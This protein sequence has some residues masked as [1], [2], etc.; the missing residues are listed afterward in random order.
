VSKGGSTPIANGT[1]DRETFVRVFLSLFRSRRTGIL[2]IHFGKKSRKLYFLGGEPIAFRSD[3]PEDD[4]GRTLVNAGLIAEKQVNWIRQKL[5]EGEVLEQAIVMSG[6][7]TTSQI[8]EHKRGRL[9]AN[10]GSPLLWGS[11]TWAF[12]PR[13][14]VRVN[15]IDPTLRPETGSLAALWAA[16][17]QH[18]SMDEVFPAVTD[19]KAGL[20]GL[21]P[22]CGALF[23][24]LEVSD[25]FSGVVDAIGPGSTVEDIFR[26]VPDNTGNLVKLLWFLEAAGLVHRE[27]R[28]RDPS[29]N[30]MIQSAFDNWKPAAAPKTTQKAAAPKTTQKAAAPK[31]ADSGGSPKKAM[32]DEAKADA[33]GAKKRRPP[34]TDDQIRSTHRKRIGRDFYSFLGLPP[35]SPKPAIDRKCKGLARRW[36]LPGKQ[37]ALSPE[38]NQKVGELLAGVQLV[39]R[40][41]TN[42][43]HRAEYDKRMEQGR[44]PKVGEIHGGSPPGETGGS[45]GIAADEISM[46]PAHQRAR[47]HMEQDQYTDA[48]KLLKQARVDDPSSPDIMA[49]IG[50]A[51]WKIQGAKNG[52]A[53]EFLRLAL[54]FDNN[55]A[56]GLEFLA[57]VMVD[58]GNLDVAQTLIVRLSKVA[59]DSKWAKKALQNLKKGT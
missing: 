28:P 32:P 21:D 19:P 53:E 52:D 48:L 2:D 22:L 18:V 13:P 27:G 41:L 58:Q 56:R 15:Q 1:H 8:A 34:L 20:V 35:S 39:W 11:G 44:A 5:T 47:A 55:H 3:L 30:E 57:K 17:G 33:G 36:R 54:T 25:A 50:W 7:L 6:S 12:E 23:P 59:P 37:R 43:T 45:A 24:S 9:H 42:E 46:N 26:Q 38:I 14:Q 4:L 40:T 49:D 29:L 31:A 51:T 16:V 10:I